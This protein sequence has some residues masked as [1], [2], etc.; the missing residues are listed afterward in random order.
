MAMSAHEPC[1]SNASC[2]LHANKLVLTLQ[3][4][5]QLD[6]EEAILQLQASYPR[7]IRGSHENLVRLI[8]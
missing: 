3:Q 2:T 8:G 1:Y 7:R 6:R 5:S 4:V